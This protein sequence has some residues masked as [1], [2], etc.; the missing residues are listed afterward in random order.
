M[1]ILTVAAAIFLFSFTLYS[2]EIPKTKTVIIS[3]VFYNYY[4]FK[5]DLQ[6]IYSMQ[7]FST[8]I[9]V[10]QFPGKSSKILLTVTGLSIC[11]Q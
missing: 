3:S 7:A 2:G 9:P 8:L 4:V 6:K 1:R 10:I 11:S 5:K